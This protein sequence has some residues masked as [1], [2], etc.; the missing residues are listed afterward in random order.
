MSQLLDLPEK[1]DFGFLGHIVMPEL[2][3]DEL[4]AV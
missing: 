3:I 1:Q 2:P 4:L